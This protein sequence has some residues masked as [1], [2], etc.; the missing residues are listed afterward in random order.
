LALLTGH[1]TDQTAWFLLMLPSPF[2]S[3]TGS[4]VLVGQ[5]APVL[6]LAVAVPKMKSWPLVVC[7]WMAF[8]VIEEPLM[9]TTTTVRL[10]RLLCLLGGHT[11]E[12]CPA[13]GGSDAA[14]QSAWPVSRR[15]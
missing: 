3:A 15:A 6:A 13:G 14:D 8:T 9:I 2:A 11:S 12:K 10:A 1:R 5:P 4:G 7:T